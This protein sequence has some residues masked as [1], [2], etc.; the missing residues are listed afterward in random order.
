MKPDF[1]VSLSFL[2]RFSRW[3]RLALLVAVYSSDLAAAGVCD[4][5]PQVR[6]KI[7]E[8]T[9]VE[10]C[11]DVTA[12]DLAAIDPD[13]STNWR[14]D[15]RHTGLTELK[16]GDF[17]GMVNLGLITMQFNRLTTLPEGVFRGL[18][19]LRLVEV[20][21]NAL[22]ELPE[23]LFRDTPRLAYFIARDNQLKTLPEGIFRNLGQLEELL[24]KNNR[25]ERLPVGLFRDTP[26]LWQLW[27]HGNELET[28]PDGIFDGLHRLEV[29]LLHEN[30]LRELPVGLF[31][32][33][34]SVLT[35]WLG[36][37][38][39]E[40]LPDGLFDGLETLRSLLLD[41]NRLRDLPVGIF[42]DSKWVHTLWLDFNPLSHL[43]VG[44]FDGLERLESLGLWD[45]RLK[46]VPEGL[47]RGLTELLHLRLKG[48]RLT[49]LPRGVFRGLDNMGSLE[50]QDNPDLASLPAGILD[51][52]LDTLGRDKTVRHLSVNSTYLG[53]LLLDPQLQTTVAFASPGQRAS[54]GELL[55]ITVRLSRPA[56]AAVRV[57]FTIVGGEEG[58]DYT[59]L[60]P[61]PAEGL[62]FAAGE[63]EKTIRLRLL[64]TGEARAKTLTLTLASLEGVRVRRSDGA[65]PDAPF[66]KAGELV[67]RPEGGAT[68][69]IGVAPFDGARLSE[70]ALAGKQLVLEA[71][72]AGGGWQPLTVVFAGDGRFEIAGSA[73]RAG[74][75]TYRRTAAHQGLVDLSFAEGAFCTLELDFATGD[76]G[77]VRHD[78]G[79]SAALEGSFRLMREASV[80]FVPV[81]LSA[82]GLKGSYFTTELTLVNL[83]PGEAPLILR[84]RAHVG[85]G[86]GTAR[87]V[88]PA[89]RQK[90]IPNVL[91]YLGMLGLPIPA[92]GKRMGTLEVDYPTGADIRVMA[93]TT[94][95]VPEGRAGLAYPAVRGDEA[96]TEPVYLCGL[97]QNAA[98]RSNV[99]VQNLGTPAD[100]PITL[101]ITVYSG[102]PEA[103]AR[104]QLPDVSL[105]PGGFH[106]YSGVLGEIANG[107]A[108]V[109]RV[110]GTGGFYAYGVIND[111]GNSDG[112]FV[113]PLRA[114]P[115]AGSRGQILPVVVETGRY[116]TELVLTNFSP[117]AKTLELSL[118]PDPVRDK[119]RTVGV[120]IRLEP[121]QQHILPRVLRQW[122]EQGVEGLLSP[123]QAPLY[124]RAVE[125]DMSGIGI[126]A[127]TGASGGGG[128]YSLFYPA[129]P[130]GEGFRTG[131]WVFGLQQDGENRSNL[132]VV[133]TGEH[134]VFPNRVSLDLYDGDTGERVHTVSG[135][136]V[137]G[138]QWR[139]FNSILANYA[140]GVRQGYVRVRI[141][142]VSVGANPFLAYGVINDGGAP[143]ERSGDGAYLPAV[144]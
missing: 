138:R 21:A 98:D 70:A 11:E 80:A 109:E 15:L 40:R 117:E 78:C 86:S 1:S 136:W 122:R 90:V 95:R 18:D 52:V 142:P 41:R 106:Q 8:Y 10:R 101:R 69:R 91:D 104:R 53:K 97:R 107:Y 38:E 114:H 56:A 39:L 37:N 25:L 63:T 22:T 66:L 5:T 24:L 135:S 82:P 140:P 75:Y 102:D 134:V 129:V 105:P 132:A 84:Y 121:G 131:A 71:V 81:V 93:R 43:P 29:L 19:R 120:S 89:G 3:M 16:P 7:L 67:V 108:R 33:L 127:R 23:G 48:N 59:G 45:T 12:E 139:Q 94:T 99:A 73:G 31:R 100:D 85:G 9:G 2:P 74:N 51:D 128:L 118:A 47:F 125:G 14:F 4:R 35:L 133:N 72:D 143:G 20:D 113:F 49:E 65:G 44:I 144:D 50:L 137:E 46:E 28:L 17:E 42:R 26:K 76:W 103:P 6:D 13:F 119:Q 30:R 77:T 57:P 116:A 115:P 36:V 112:S 88:L 58:K 62:L 27:L 96:F 123:L 64:E 60:S 130:F 92:E 61:D 126:G 124:A 141:L 34:D 54:G 110:A 55:Q 79:G 68:H 87:A 83:G 32:D 111:Q